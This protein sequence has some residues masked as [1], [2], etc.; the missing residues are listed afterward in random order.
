M[1]QGSE[2]SANGKKT[3][4]KSKMLK[5]CITIFS[6]FLLLIGIASSYVNYAGTVSSLEQTMT[7][8]A[9]LAA[10]SITHDL[11][12]YEILAKELSYNEILRSKTAG[13]A[14]IAEECE[15]LAQRNGVAGVGAGDASGMSRT[16]DISLAE[17]EYFKAAKETGKT[18]ISDPIVRRDNGEMN[19]I[20]SAPI[21]EEGKFQGI[22]YVALDASFLCE[23]VSN[24]NIGNTGNAS[25]INKKGDTIGYQDVQL[26]LDAYNT[27]NELANDKGLAQLA[28]VERKVMAGEAGFDTYQY[29]G[30]SKFAAYC[31]VEGTNGWGLYV[32]VEKNEFLSSTYQGIIFIIVMVVLAIGVAVAYIGRFAS[33]ISAPIQLCVNRIQ[34]LAQGDI[35][36]EVPR[37]DTGDEI[38]VLAE[39]AAVLAGNVEKVIGDIDYCLKEISTGNFAVHTRAEESYAGDFAS[40]LASMRS[41][42]TTLSGTM[43]SITEVSDQVAMGSGQ[44]AESAQTLAEGATEQAGAVEELM[45]AISTVSSLAAE[46]AQKA[47]DSYKNA[48]T[49]ARVAENSNRDMQRLTEAMERINETSR[50]IANIISAI[51][52]IASQTN[53]LSLNASI[54]AARA[55]E[56]GRGFAVV[57]DQIGKLASDS[58][59][60]AVSTRELIEKSMAEIREG[61]IVT[62]KTAEALKEVI[63]G[64][65]TFAGLASES[66]QAS[67]AQSDSIREL[68]KGMEQISMVV[69]NNSAA[70]EE[71]SATSEELSAQSENLNTMVGRFKLKQE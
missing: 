65:E 40:I 17:Q 55:G 46:S 59:K 49:L 22:V 6:V 34:A 26:V 44:M 61:N 14:E 12:T 16:D 2:K 51:E 25:L 41:L 38:Q 63:E 11:E 66:S 71:T 56:A 52:E 48:G 69:Q 54:E 21:M 43:R 23:L 18:Y 3:T 28:A 10:E 45:G 47:E 67:R 31:P 37:I 42:N 68:E 29:G 5:T 32:A 60:S 62:T 1:K 30:V 9:E 27:Q 70:A 39:S 15:K 35:H 53:M 64:M 58:S 57:A 50:E 13:P 24:I 19:I 7:E 33:K 20:I 36:S 8:T 4:I